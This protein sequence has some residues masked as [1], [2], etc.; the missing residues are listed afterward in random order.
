MII[1]GTE[2][3]R[4]VLNLSSIKQ[5]LGKKSACNIS[6]NEFW[7]NDVQTA[8]GMGFITAVGGGQQQNVE[9]TV[10]CTN[11]HNKKAISL[12]ALNN[13]AIYPSERFYL[14]E[15]DLETPDVRD[16]IN[17]GII[18]IVKVQNV[19]PVQETDLVMEEPQNESAPEVVELETNEALP[20]LSQTIEK[21]KDPISAKH[22]IWN[23]NRDNKIVAKIT[24]NKTSPTKIIDSETPDPVN[25]NEGDPKRAVVLSNPNSNVHNSMKNAVAWNPTGKTIE[26]TY[27]PERGIS[28]VDDDAERIAKHPVLSKTKTVTVEADPIAPDSIEENRIAKHPVLSKQV[29]N[30]EIDLG[31]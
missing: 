7:N 26:K 18:A 1:K 6:E 9:K 21:T 20:T 12:K 14:K 13:R 22:I 2:K 3:I 5:Q 10:Q 31:E 16:A 17:K 23:A 30:S 19:Q 24:E 11:I 4:G 29:Q 27:K 8:L 15:S 28:F 25:A